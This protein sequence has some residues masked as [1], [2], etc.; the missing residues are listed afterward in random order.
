MEIILQNATYACFK[1]EGLI[2]QCYI[3]IGPATSMFVRSATTNCL[4]P[5]PILKN[6]QNEMI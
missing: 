2:V 3:V 6:S 1:L 5:S 4:T